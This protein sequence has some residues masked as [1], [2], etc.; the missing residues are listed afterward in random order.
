MS[1]RIISPIRL[2]LAALLAPALAAPALACPPQIVVERPCASVADG[3]FLLVHASRGCQ[4]GKLTVTGTAE[5]LVGGARRSIPLEISATGTDGV[6]RCGGS[7]RPGRVGAAA[8]RAGGRGQRDRAGRRRRLRRDRHWCASRTRRAGSIPNITDADVDAM[9]H[10]LAQ[11]SGAAGLPRRRSSRGHGSVRRAARWVL[12]LQGITAA[13][14]SPPRARAARRSGR[15]A[16]SRRGRPMPAP[17]R[18]W[19]RRSVD[20][21]RRAGTR[22][23]APA[24]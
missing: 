24:P 6:Y 3:A 9:L 22:C 15:S 8:R 21:G 19:A 18:C 16:P 23:S 2:A 14:P 12:T 7:G 4:S 10:S 20:S 5:G 13:G 11:L 17:R 1:G